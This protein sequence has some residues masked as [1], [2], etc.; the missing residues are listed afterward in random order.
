[1]SERLQERPTAKELSEYQAWLFDTDGTTADTSE[2]AIAVVKEIICIVNPDFD[3]NFSHNDV[4]TWAYIEDKFIEAG[5]TENDARLTAIAIWNYTDVLMNAKPIKGAPELVNYLYRQGKDNFSA[6]S[7]PD[8]GNIKEITKNWI[9]K[10]LKYIQDVFVN[11]SDSNVKGP[12][13]KAD[14]LIELAEK[15]GSAVLVEDFPGHVKEIL[16]VIRESGK[17]LK[18]NIILLP[19]A[20]IEVPED[21]ASDPMV[22][23]MYRDAEQGIGA[24]QEVLM[25]A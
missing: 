13:F 6:T 11:P 19:Y 24:I 3:L 1:M 20:K 2:T 21:L 4:N 18:I 10:E 7:R 5:L 23:V 22:T 25:T 12:A 16:K 15:Y 8:I 14:K 9:Y 17:D